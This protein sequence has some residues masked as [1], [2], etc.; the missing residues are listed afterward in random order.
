MLKKKAIVATTLSTL[1][2]STTIL[3]NDIKAD[4]VETGAAVTVPITEVVATEATID[5]T[6]TEA[7]SPTT[8]AVV[9]NESASDNNDTVTVLHTKDV[10]G[11]MVED[12]RNGVIGDPPLSGIVN[13]TRS[14]GT[15]LVFDSG[16]SF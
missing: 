1:L 13:D 11:R 7:A 2:V 5:E 16:D 14:K 15:T 3:A 9:T 12:D 8:P 4:E 10:H 6:S